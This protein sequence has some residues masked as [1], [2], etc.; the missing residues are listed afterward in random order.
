VVLTDEGRQCST[1]SDEGGSPV[2]RG[3]QWALV[4]TRKASGALE[5][6]DP[7]GK[8]EGDGAFFAPKQSEGKKGN[9]VWRGVSGRVHTNKGG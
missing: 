8:R 4:G 9:G 1:N 6:P 7:R 2:A 5:W 3:G